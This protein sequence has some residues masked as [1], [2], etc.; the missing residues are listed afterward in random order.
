MTCPT[1][2]I[3]TPIESQ[4]HTPIYRMHRYFA[5]R[6]HNLINA[7]IQHYTRP[8]DVI[9][10]PFCGGG[11]T[12]VEGLRLKRKVIGIDLNPMAVFITRCEVMNLDVDE[13][14]RT[15]QAIAEMTRDT[16]NELYRT[17]CPKCGCEATTDWTTWSVVYF[18][19]HCNQAV[20]TVESE[21]LGPGKYRCPACAKSF[22]VTGI[23]RGHDQMI[24]QHVSCS[25]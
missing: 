13:L 10:D 17:K 14:E 1:I 4:P 16:I 20:V 6:P 9:L 19:P 11:T 15:I 5:R 2:P 12:I 3:L 24:R 18:C 21:K 23:A 8:G 22:T 25:A 7:L